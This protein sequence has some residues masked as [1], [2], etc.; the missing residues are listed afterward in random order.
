MIKCKNS[1]CL[2][3]LYFL[4]RYFPY[5]M[6]I[7]AT[8]KKK[9]LNPNFTPNPILILWRNGD[10]N[11]VLEHSTFD[12]ISALFCFSCI[13]SDSLMICIS[14]TVLCNPEFINYNWLMFWFH[15]LPICFLDKSSKMN[16]W[17]QFLI[18]EKR[19]KIVIVFP[20]FKVDCKN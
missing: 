16:N 15:Q 18:V 17:I 7:F 4:E 11:T 6:K 8:P 1:C 3:H 2:A 12:L 9:F 5:K 19:G 20:N 14:L 10:S 13:V